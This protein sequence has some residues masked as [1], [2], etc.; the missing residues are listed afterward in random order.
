M[1]ASFTGG[2]ETTV[3]I[4]GVRYKIHT[5]TSSGTLT[6]VSP[7]DVEYL[8]VGGGGAGG[9][10]TGAG[11]GGGGAGGLLTGFTSLTGTQTIT[12]GAGGTATTDQDGGDGSNSSI[13]SLFVAIGGGGGAGPTP[14]NGRSG[15]SGGGASNWR[16]S[17]GGAGS[18]TAGQG[19]AGGNSNSTN[20]R[21]G[22]GGGAGGAGGDGNGTLG[23][24][25]GI[26]STSFITGTGTAVV[27]AGG[28]GGG[29]DDA[30]ALGG[31]GGGGNGATPSV[32]ATAGAANTGG[33]GGGGYTGNGANGGS[34]IVIIR[35]ELEWELDTQTSGSWV[36]L[37]SLP[38]WNPSTQTSGSWVRFTSLPDW[39]PTS[40]SQ[41]SGSWVRLTSLPDWNPTSQSQTSGS[42]V[43]FTSFELIGR[44][45]LPS[46]VAVRSSIPTPQTADYT[47]L[48]PLPDTDPGNL[49]SRYSNAPAFQTRRQIY[50]GDFVRGPG[51]WKSF[52]RSGTILPEGLDESLLVSQPYE[53]DAIKLWWGVPPEA[54]G[55]WTYMALV[56]SGFGHPSTPSDGEV[57]LGLDGN[58]PDD[59]VP[60]AVVDSGLPQGRWF[61]YTL[62]F[63]VGTRWYPV[64]R[65]QNVVPIDYAHRDVLYNE[66]PPFYQRVDAERYA[67]TN[68]SM[69]GRWYSLIGYELDL[70]R[71]LTEGVEN[72]YDPDTS[73]QSLLDALAVQNLG[74]TKS[75]ALGDIRHRG[76]VAQ[77]GTLLPQRGTFGGLR[78]LVRAATQYEARVSPGR[79]LLLLG[80]DARFAKGKGNWSPSHYGL[81]RALEDWRDIE[82]SPTAATVTSR[83]LTF[84]QGALEAEDY[85]DDL[86]QLPKPV[87]TCTEI[88]AGAGS[89]EH[90]VVACGAGQQIT[91]QALD[92]E[93]AS[94]ARPDSLSYT[95]FQNLPAKSRVVSREKIFQLTHLNPVTRGI[96]VNEETEY[97]FSF[98]M[99][100]TSASTE[101]Y[102]V[103]FG[104]AFY[105][106]DLPSAGFSDAFTFSG[107]ESYGQI[108]PLSMQV[109]KG[110]TVSDGEWHR[111]I[112]SAEAP[113]DARYTVPVIWVTTPTGGRIAT[114]RYLSAAMVSEASKADAG[115]LFRPDFYFRVT[116]N[117]P[118]YRMGSGSNKVIGEP[119]T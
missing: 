90:L 2:T 84:T 87:S 39:N 7:G 30:V 5:F 112:M 70:L 55:S 47:P 10:H 6:M 88:I 20:G 62:M 22:G 23:G 57:I 61:Y 113:E 37:T 34:G 74:L 24:G 72:I 60:G 107:F 73:P 3:T 15:G 19:N 71:T 28:G 56:R 51:G 114:K 81:N 41:T 79:N 26:G 4:S 97:Y 104:L 110:A 109:V 99:S 42:W 14:G 18:G 80:D 118:N 89:T 44:L 83:K 29:D 96:V 105:E 54:T 85:P 116:E 36:R 75:D 17:F 27:Y 100:A 76:V 35:Y 86:L 69:L 12:V 66:T 67:G 38:D 63:K 117:N 98:W 46:A 9:S 40:Q 48:P 25:G 65:T 101:S 31:L 64:Q 16:A 106:R 33:G 45:E 13:G 91:V 50:D 108:E 43:R 68:A 59:E 93:T 21:G 92:V 8:V 78:E 95:E 82:Y 1:P 53:Y 77:Y 103:N 94:Q 11:L 119:R 102:R 115:E 49:L 58:R 52:L 32:A 111:Y